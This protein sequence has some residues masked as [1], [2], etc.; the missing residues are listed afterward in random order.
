MR[1]PGAD[2]GG[3]GQLVI[4]SAG[5]ATARSPAAAPT[6]LADEPTRSEYDRTMTKQALITGITGQD[7]SYLAEFL[8]DQGYEVVGMV[9]RSSTV[10]FERIAH[11]QDQVSLAPGDLLDEVS[12]IE[13]REHAPPRSTTWPRSPSCRPR[14]PSQCSRARLRQSV[15]PGCSTPFAWSTPTFASTKRAAAK[16]FG[17]VREVPQSEDTP[18]SLEPLRRGQG[19]RPL[20]H[21]ELPRVLRPAR[22]VGGVFNHESP[23]RGLEFVTRKIS[24]AVAQIKL[25][26]DRAASREPRGAA[27]LGLRR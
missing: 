9:R 27:G 13:M 1:R 6:H 26:R 5:G 4:S 24:H 11:I 22:H 21:G 8:L 15:S 18:L 10:N 20:D 17:K 16:M 19:L 23:R 7:E 25:A 12:L 2:A 14:S 3:H